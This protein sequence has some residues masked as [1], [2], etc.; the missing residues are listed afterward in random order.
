M[1]FVIMV[2]SAKIK[3]G[4]NGFGRIGRLVARV[5]LERD[6]IELVAINDPFITPEYMTYMF[7]YDSTHGQWKKT[8]VTLH[9]EGHLTFGGNPVAVYACRDPSEI[10]WGKHGADFVVESTGVFTDKDKAAAHLKVKCDD[11]L[12]C[13]NE[14]L[15][16]LQ[17]SKI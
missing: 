3:V 10:P 6:D 11:T 12:F 4:I 2:G 14:F 5:A 8:E 13:N 16:H 9:S 1:K 7:K 15:F 17:F